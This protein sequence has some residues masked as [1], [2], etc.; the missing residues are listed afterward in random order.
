[1]RDINM[2]RLNTELQNPE[3]VGI[4]TCTTEEILQKINK[5]D[6]QVPDVVNRQISSITKLVDEAFQS[7]Q[8]GGR[9]FYVGAGTSGRLGILD[10]SECPPTYGVSEELIQGV[11][12][13]GIPAVFK[14][15]EGA[16][17]SLGQA[18]R[19]LIEKGLSKKDMVIGVAASGR[20][21]YVIGA[22]EYA[23]SLGTGTG[24][25]CCVEQG[26]ISQYADYPVEVV[27]GPEVVTGSTRMKAGTAQKLVLN[28][29][30][31]AVM[32]KSGKVFQ[33]YMV[34]V[35][36]TNEKLEKRARNIIKV[37]TGVDDKR[38][39]T[40]FLAS[41]KHVKTAI[42]MEIC[43]ISKEE[44]K[45]LLKHNGGHISKCITNVL[46]EEE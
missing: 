20:T 28:M 34:D 19:D 17:D 42:V 10:A 37:I 38:A 43:Q 44:A 24:S 29:I 31:T 1:M 11:I 30:S 23:K 26:E 13:G 33:N 25:I 12:A 40:L 35:Q 9:I 41:G 7:I 8:K 4:D 39:D 22:L 18:K 16:E 36:P 6:Q 14:A 5:E 21:P 45:Q 32:I 27:T 15:Q 2:E 46:K 3:T